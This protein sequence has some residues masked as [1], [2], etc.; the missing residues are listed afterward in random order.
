MWRQTTLLCI[1][2][3]LVVLGQPRSSVAAPLRFAAIPIKVTES[4]VE[5]QA[6]R[7]RQAL[8]VTLSKRGLQSNST[9]EIDHLLV[10]TDFSCIKPACLA[11]TSHVLKVDVLIGGEFL[12]KNKQ[13]GT[14]KLW[15]YH[16]QDKKLVRVEEKICLR[17]T[18][19]QLIS[20]I[21]PLAGRLLSRVQGVDPPARL[22]I[23]SNPQ[24][25]LARV[26]GTPV[27]VSDMV[28]T[29]VPGYHVVTL[30]RDGYELFIREVQ[31][32]SGKTVSIVAALTPA[33][34]TAKTSAVVVE[35]PVPSKEGLNTSRSMPPSRRKFAPY[36]WASLGVGVLGLATG[37][38][39]MVVDGQA[40]CDPKFPYA[41]CPK[42][43]DTFTPGA[44]LTGL[45]A[46]AAIGAGILF[47]LDY[48]A[49]TTAEPIARLA[50][51]MS[52]TAMGLVFR[53]PLIYP[54]FSSG[55]RTH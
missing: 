15:L 30:H 55:D 34:P 23:R 36:K 27:G 52:P 17:C 16:A 7:L 53:A 2:S 54:R 10:A 1:W 31:V 38:P 18:S 14:L 46:A 5:S 48:T 50:P 42:V 37:I 19:T 9:S 32:L 44:L 3:S 4:S 43:R 49:T 39:L 22:A 40:T 51:F 28:L 24:G 20:E 35:T 25:A 11:D 21:R 33:A 8:T 29:L 41:V 12:R 26:D 45:G 47:Y 13:H 6:S